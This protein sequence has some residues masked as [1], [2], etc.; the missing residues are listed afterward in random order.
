MRLTSAYTQRVPGVNPRFW[1]HLV[2]NWRTWGWVATQQRDFVLDSQRSPGRA[3]NPGMNTARMDQILSLNMPAEEA[4][5][6]RRRI[7]AIREFL[8][9]DAESVSH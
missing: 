3:Y 5:E 7:L 1:T 6:W 4:D 2:L 8:R 9:L